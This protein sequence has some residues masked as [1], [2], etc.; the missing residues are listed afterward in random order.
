MYDIVICDDD[1]RFIRYMH[2][3]ILASGLSDGEV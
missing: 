3:L 1:E 2:K